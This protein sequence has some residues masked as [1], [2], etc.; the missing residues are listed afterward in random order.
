MYKKQI[1]LETNTVLVLFKRPSFKYGQYGVKCEYH[2]WFETLKCVVV[3]L[4]VSQ[5]N[6]SSKRATNLLKIKY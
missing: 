5:T 1:C 3:F 2:E 6:H 4:L